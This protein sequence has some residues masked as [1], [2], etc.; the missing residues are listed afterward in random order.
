M[1]KWREIGQRQFI[2]VPTTQSGVTELEAQNAFSTN[3]RQNHNQ[4]V[5]LC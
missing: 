4:M 3:K 5:R 1:Q 2:V